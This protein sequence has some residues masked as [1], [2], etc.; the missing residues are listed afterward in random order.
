M[1]GDR[2]AQ[3]RINADE[4][5]MQAVQGQIAHPVGR[6]NPYRIGH[7]GVPIT[8]NPAWPCITMGGRSSA[9]PTAR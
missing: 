2:R 3:L 8:W 9:P 1:P 6:E 5:V 7:D 4:L